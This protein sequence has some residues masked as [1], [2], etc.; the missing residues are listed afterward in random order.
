[1]CASIVSRITNKVF[2]FRA[3]EHQRRPRTQLFHLML[4]HHLTRSEW[5]RSNV[6]CPLHDKTTIPDNAIAVSFPVVLYSHNHC[7]S[8]QWFDE[9]LSCWKQ[10]KETSNNHKPLLS[11]TSSNTTTL[12]KSKLGNTLPNVASTTLHLQP[13]RCRFVKVITWKENIGSFRPDLFINFLKGVMGGELV[14]GGQCFVKLKKEDCKE[15][16]SMG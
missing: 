3:I 13:S 9:V 16:T 4:L 6:V 14:M 11:H 7:P 1:M 2:F 8:H 15:Y 10:W 5:L 12:F